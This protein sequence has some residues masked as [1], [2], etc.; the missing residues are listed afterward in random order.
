MN[1]FPLTAQQTTLYVQ[2]CL[3]RKDEHQFKF[4]L[5]FERSLYVF[6]PSFALVCARVASLNLHL[7]GPSVRGGLLLWFLFLSV[8]GE[9]D[10]VN[11]FIMYILPVV[12]TCFLITILDLVFNK[13]YKL[14]HTAEYGYT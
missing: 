1:T 13:M 9:M 2:M 3:G 10:H 11:V 14:V 5:K 12:F 7:C 8:C 6:S 4:I